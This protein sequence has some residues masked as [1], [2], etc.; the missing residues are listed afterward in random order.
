M[1]RIARR[2]IKVSEGLREAGRWGSI[3]TREFWSIEKAKFEVWGGSKQA[4]NFAKVKTRL[5]LN[6]RS[7]IERDIYRFYGVIIRLDSQITV[8]R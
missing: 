6:V 2:K 8:E 3:L 7:E 4:R 1:L 5:F